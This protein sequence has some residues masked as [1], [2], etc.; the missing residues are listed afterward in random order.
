MRTGRTKAGFVLLLTLI[1]GATG[2]TSAP[3]KHGHEDWTTFYHQL[4]ETDVAAVVT[5]AETLQSLSDLLDYAEKHNTGLRAAFET[6]TAALEQ[7]P[8]S[9]SLPDPRISYAWF[10]ESVETRVGPQ[11]QKFGITQ[12]IPL[13]G[14]LGARGNVAIHAANVAGADFERERLSLRLRVTTLW[15]DY[16]YLGRAIETTEE[17]L[18]LMT[19][20]E[21]VALAQYAAGRTS[22]SSAIRAQVELGKLEDRLRTLRDQRSALVASLNAELDRPTTDDIPWPDSTAPRSLR[23]KPDSLQGLLRNHNPQLL[24][25]RSRAARDSAAATLAGKSAIPDLTIGAEY[26]ET[27]PA[28]NPGT[29][30]SGKDAAMLMA[31]INVPLW[32]GQYRAESAQANASRAAMAYELRQKEARLQAELETARFQYRDAERRIELYAYTLLPK[33]RQAFEV[34]EDAFT[35]GDASF[36]DLIDTQRTL[37]EFELSYERA[38]ADQSTRLA[39]LETLVGVDLTQASQEGSAP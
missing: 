8:Q 1:V 4:P 19:H 25:L 9:T 5:Q 3:K 13:F 31:S 36:L 26:I 2:C 37:L 18:R 23:A 30:D 12:T 39:Q 28:A 11:R 7:V 21:N 38:L 6:W 27:G 33:A 24:A 32:F 29:P 15:N 17:N 10:L 20:L 16:Y 35:A 34:T 14:K 22:H